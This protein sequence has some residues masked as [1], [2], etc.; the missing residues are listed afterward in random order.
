[1]ATFELSKLLDEELTPRD[2]EQLEKDQDL[3]R[4]FLKAKFDSSC[5]DILGALQ[6]LL[7]IDDDGE[8]CDENNDVE[9]DTI[10]GE[11]EQETIESD[12]EVSDGHLVKRRKL[13]DIIEV[14][15]D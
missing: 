14:D 10:H 7:K 1:M 2:R 6:D 13:G 15:E 9:G 11:D 12:D 3:M 5:V 8:D 4:S